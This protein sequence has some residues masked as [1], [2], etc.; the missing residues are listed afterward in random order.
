MK[1]ELVLGRG[2]RFYFLLFPLEKE[3]F[4]IYIQNFSPF[5]PRDIPLGSCFFGIAVRANRNKNCRS[6]K[7]PK[8]NIE[9]VD[10]WWQMISSNDSEN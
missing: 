10:T 6:E 5:P 8:H 4:R 2:A 3:V 1:L 9:Y 7:D